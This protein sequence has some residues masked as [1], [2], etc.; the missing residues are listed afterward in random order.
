V[1]H[2]FDKEELMAL[3]RGFAAIREA[4]KESDANRAAFDA[5]RTRDFLL[6]E[7]GDE[8]EV[9]FIGTAD[10]EPFMKKMHTVRGAG[11]MKFL[12]DV[13][14]VG[15]EG[16]D[17]CVE[18]WAEASG[19]KRIGKARKK[20]VF[21]LVDT[22]FVHKQKNDEKTAGGKFEKF[23]WEECTCPDEDP[24][25][26]QCKACKRKMPR[27]RRGLAKG[28]WGIQTLVAIDGLN[29]QLGRKCVSCGKGRIKITGY[30]NAKG[31]VLPDI[32]DVDNPE[33][34]APQ[35]E[36][37]KCDDPKPGNIFSCPITIRRNGKGEST[38]YTFTPGTFECPPDWVLE[39][40][41]LELEKIMVPR[42]SEAQAKLL[43]IQNPFGGS[44]PARRR[45]EASDYN[46]GGTDDEE[47]P[48]ETED[49]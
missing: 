37:T 6:M 48:F 49:E 32:E 31:K 35:Y 1:T 43:A 29:Q 9:W 14:A 18:C 7:D 41:P 30:M 40:E 19:D 21:S 17:G 16:H 39:I 22:R 2:P 34:W 46:A 12:E 10:T 26:K 44:R 47:D 24:D 45:D 38:T 42:S 36:C 11:K 25:P 27:E 15:E 3:Q 13:C 8:A 28:K 23:D 33:N 4:K 20:G 5:M